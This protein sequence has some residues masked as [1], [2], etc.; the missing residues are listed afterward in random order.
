M[1]TSLKLMNTSLPNGGFPLIKF[2]NKNNEIKKKLSKERHYSSNIKNINIRKI[3]NSNINKTN[4]I[5]DHDDN[6]E[7]IEEV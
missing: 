5:D 7:I 1:N 3:I 6:S 4:I 2:C